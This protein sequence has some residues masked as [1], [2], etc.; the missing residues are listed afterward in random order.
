MAEP[1]ASLTYLEPS[2]FI[3]SPAA[4]EVSAIV[5]FEIFMDLLVKVSV[6]SVPIRVVVAVGKVNVPEFDIVEMTGAV[7]VLLVRVSVV[8]LPTKV[9]V[10]VGIVSV[11]V[12]TI[13]PITGDVNVLFVNVSVVSL[14]TKVVVAAGKVTVT[15]DDNVSV[16]IDEVEPESDILSRVDGI[17]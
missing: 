16:A 8:V 15:L 6:V 2:D 7:R 5:L 1:L 12:L 13:V 4:L 3:I 17:V 14:P 10:V 11:P 9:V